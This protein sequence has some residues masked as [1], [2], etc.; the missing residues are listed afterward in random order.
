LQLFSSLTKENSKAN[1]RIAFINADWQDFQ[2]VS[3][4]EENPARNIC[5]IAILKPM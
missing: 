5:W 2:G 1:A 3:V 4:L